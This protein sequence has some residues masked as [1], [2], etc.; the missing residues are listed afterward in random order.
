MFKWNLVNLVYDCFCL[1]KLDKENVFLACFFNSRFFSLLSIFDTSF[2][3]SA[4]LSSLVQNLKTTAL[5]SRASGTVEGYQRAFNRWKLFA[6]QIL[7]AHHFP[8]S[9]I[10]FAL[11]IQYL[12]DQTNSAPTINTAFYAINWTHKLA[13]LDSP[14]DH[15]TVLLIKEAAVRMCSQRISRKEPLEP[16]HLKDLANKTN[17]E[18]LQLRS[19]VIYDVAT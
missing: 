15:S 3:N 16:V 9:P 11:Y 5:A 19:L 12:V 7:Q 10:D 18:D 2:W 8:V 6:T 4:I 1:N 17:L 13:G 14:T